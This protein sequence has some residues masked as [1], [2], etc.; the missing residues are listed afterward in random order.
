[1]LM[2]RTPFFLLLLCGATQTLGIIIQSNPAIN[3]EGTIQVDAQ[4][5]VSLKCEVDG[6]IPADEELV[7]LRNG[8]MVQLSDDNKKGHSSVCVT[9]VLTEDNDAIFTCHLQTNK[10]DKASVTLNVTYAPA[11]SGT[12]EI[13]VEL[14]SPLVLE[15]DMRANPPVS[16]MSWTLNGS[17]VDLLEG[18]FTVTNNGITS[19]LQV[20]SVNKHLHEATY[21]CTAVSPMFPESSQT[22]DVIVTEKTLNFPLMPII[23]GVVVVCATA[24]LAIVSR[25]RK[26]RQCFK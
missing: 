21:K 9:P 14:E 10:S 3:S 1:M 16:S 11:L 5:T 6:D 2:F 7:W 26:I 13:K 8:A 23:A 12:E 18:G 15:C 20:N 4:K 22:F 24:L 25:W 17:K 19:R